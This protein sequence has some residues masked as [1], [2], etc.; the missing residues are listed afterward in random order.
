M[1][2]AQTDKL[3]LFLILLVVLGVIGAVLAKKFGPS[4]Q[5]TAS[6]IADANTYTS[7]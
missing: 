3:F 2:R 1:R 4:I 5:N 7:L 6:K